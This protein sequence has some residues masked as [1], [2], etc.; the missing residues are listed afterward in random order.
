MLNEY[1]QRS[2][3]A[4]PYLSTHKHS[5]SHSISTSHKERMIHYCAHCDYNSHYRS[6]VSRHQSRKHK[7]V[8]EEVE[9]FQEPMQSEE[10][11]TDWDLMEDSI[12]VF[13]IYKLLQRM[14]NK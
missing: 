5:T 11:F 12:E 14:K 9:E 3:L 6:N 2:L 1:I 8:K 10:Q 7:M 4:P 13:K